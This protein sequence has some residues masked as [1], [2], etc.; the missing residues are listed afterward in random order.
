MS[1]YNLRSLSRLSDQPLDQM[2]D[3]LLISTLKLSIHNLQ[4]TLYLNH[5]VILH[6]ILFKISQEGLSFC[7]SQADPQ[8]DC[9]SIGQALHQASRQGPCQGYSLVLTGH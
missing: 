8:V 4:V 3:L 2:V 9:K 6:L 1:F 5:R 7:L